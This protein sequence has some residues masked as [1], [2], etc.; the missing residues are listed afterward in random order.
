MSAY[1]ISLS[2][3]TGW[4]H[5]CLMTCKKGIWNC[6]WFFVALPPKI[7][8][9]QWRSSTSIIYG[10]TFHVPGPSLHGMV[11]S[12]TIHGTMAWSAVVTNPIRQAF[13]S[14]WF[15]QFSLDYCPPPL[16]STT[17]W[18]GR[19]GNAMYCTLTGGVGILLV[20]LHLCQSVLYKALNSS[21]FC[22]DSRTAQTIEILD[23]WDPMTTEAGLCGGSYYKREAILDALSDERVSQLDWTPDRRMVEIGMGCI[24]G[25]C[26]AM[27]ANSR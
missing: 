21:Q 22:A 9:L 15:Y 27:D 24:D 1:W 18:V 10:C 19:P 11:H 23:L 25:Q 8:T 17:Y 4:S 13:I 16:E 12:H 7:N 14:I 3:V 6:N 2:K 26:D 20:S 5:L